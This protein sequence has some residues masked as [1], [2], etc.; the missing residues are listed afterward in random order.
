MTRGALV[1]RYRAV[2]VA[3]AASAALHAAVMV[4]L[5]GRIASIDAA[6]GDDYSAAIDASMEAAPAPAARPVPARPPARPRGR[7]HVAMLAPEPLMDSMS[8]EAAAASL[9]R[10]LPLPVIDGPAPAPPPAMPE[11]LA[12]AQPA[13]PAKALEPPRFPV[14]ALPA[15]LSISYDLTSAFADGRAV[16]NW[17]RDGDAYTITGEAEAVGFFT[18][19]L[20]GRIVQESRG[21]LTRTGLRPESFVERKPG[22]ATEGLEFDWAGG[23]VTFD[24]HNEKK[25]EALTDNTVDWLSMIFQLA[26]MPP[27]T[28][29]YDLRVLT[30]R[31]YYRFH[32]KVLGVE[33]IDIPL[34]RVNALHLRHVD[35]K[36][37]SE[38]VDV[39]LGVDQHYLPVKL[40]Y[41]VA[42]NRLVVEQSATRVTA[43]AP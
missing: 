43:R 8:P 2:A 29:D 34:G 24:R 37:A 17:S 10:A 5:P 21:K 41:P 36:D 6:P 35:E 33:T 31:K 16:Y 23:K 22:T 25:T 4:G 13:V 19:F 14:D 38:V 12:L 26:S 18:L 32:L 28:G 1:H 15:E 30:Q 39:W 42:R 27:A 40:R 11:K 9:D 3:L 7:H 20:E